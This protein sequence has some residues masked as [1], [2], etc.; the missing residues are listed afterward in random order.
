MLRALMPPVAYPVSFHTTLDTRVLVFA[1]LVTVG[2]ALL[3]GVVPAMQ[4][5]KPD[6]VVSL[7][8]GVGM[9]GRGRGLLRGTLVV[10]QISLSVIALVAAGLFIRSLNAAQRM[11]A[12]Y[13]EPERVLL[14]ST[15]LLLA[16]YNASSGRVVLRQMLDRV[17]ALPGVTSATISGIVPLGFGGNNSTSLTIEG[18]TP[19]K[20]ENMSLNNDGVGPR[21]FETVGTPLL[22]GRD[23]TAQDDSGTARVVIVNQA[24][25]KKYWPGQD[26]MGRWI[27]FGGGKRTVVG[28]VA[29]AKQKQL[30]ETP[31]PFLFLPH[32]QDYDAAV[33]MYV[34][35]S[36]DPKLLTETV[37]RTFA[38]IDPNLPFLDVRT[39][40]E[41]MGAATFFM[42]LGAIMLGLFGGARAVALEHGHLL[43]DRVLR[44]PAHA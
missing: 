43:G 37:R 29:T 4:A 6:L 2:T 33:T 24:F 16:G 19:Q 44:E 30:G 3:F 27:D 17:Q 9:G 12:G 23:F 21:F 40:A 34:R 25:A 28:V 32:A 36:G 42:K 22:Q 26:A 7:K 13:R 1:M 10:T 41:H 39:F 38:S 8:D 15:D 11:D 35:T 5:S 18:Y 31:L 20:D 14:V